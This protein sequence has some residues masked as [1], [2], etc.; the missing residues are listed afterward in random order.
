MANA[1]TAVSE[2][3][4][5]P[6]FNSTSRF[7]AG[8][9]VGILNR[10]AEYAGWKYQRGALI[11][12][13]T[14]QEQLVT[15]FINSPEFTLKFGNQT[16]ED[17]IRMLYRQVLH[18][19]AAPA[20]VAFHGNS[21]RHMTRTGVARNFLN[22]AEFRLGAERRVTVFLAHACVLD[23]DV[24]PAQASRYIEELR[25]GK[26]LQQFIADLMRPI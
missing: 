22:S 19:E 10:D 14:T 26:P 2:V 18:R 15:N 4:D 17:F 9:Y 20:E 13:T 12:G 5:W 24:S 7:V 23:R 16:N 25:R 6:Q 1:A 8:L 21:L 3:F 11:S